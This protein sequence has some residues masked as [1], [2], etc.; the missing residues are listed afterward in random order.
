VKKVVKQLLKS[1]SISNEISRKLIDNDP[2]I[3]RAY[4]L[5]KIHKADVPLRPIVS[6]IGS[7]TYKIAKWLFKK[8]KYLS[9]SSPF[10]INNTFL[11]LEKIRNLRISP[12][13]SFV[14]F[15]VT[16]LF[17]SI[18][19]ALALSTV[20]DLLT[21]RPCD[22]PTDDLI[23]LLSLCLNNYCMFDGKY[24]RQVKG[25]PMGSSI[26]GLVAEVVLQK[27]EKL[28]FQKLKPTLWVRYVDDTFVIIRKDAFAV[29]YELINSIFGDIKFTCEEAKDD[30]LPF[31]DVL[32]R[33][34][35]DGSL[36]TS[37]YRKDSSADVIL[38]YDSNH[39]ASHKRSCVQTLFKRARTHCSSKES[40]ENEIDYLYRILIENAYPNNFI[41][42]CLRK[43]KR[44]P[45]DPT[46]NETK[47]NWFSLPYIKGTSEIVARQLKKLDIGIAHKPAA[48]IR[49]KIVKAKDQMQALQKKGV[50]YRIPCTGCSGAYYGQTGKQLQ[51]RLHEHQLCIRRRDHLSQL[52]M[53][54]FESG[55]K[56]DWEQTSIVGASNSKRGRE[57]IEAW[58]STPDSFNRH[59][60]IDQAY[61]C[62]KT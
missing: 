4:G 61:L 2:T 15:D 45:L 13:E 5:P 1:K 30:S 39:P 47:H 21:D 59:V 16:S 40:L 38:N 22:V 42:E 46:E 37:V 49:S 58:N 28:A 27:L 12:D 60:E 43:P 54:T 35:P 57:F 52:A 36:Q 50:V 25:T 11:F 9:C 6:L 51:T 29:F 32:V 56:F 20:K 8:L 44:R 31:L 55:H 24:Y 7:P 3:A 62:L 19:T 33:K 41:R 48:T 53:H 34:L 18:P 26:S 14:S 17:P 23:K 10:S